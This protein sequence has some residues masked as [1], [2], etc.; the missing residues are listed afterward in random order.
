MLR[1]RCLIQIATDGPT[2]PQG[3]WQYRAIRV[4]AKATEDADAVD[5][6][7]QKWGDAGWQL[8]T[9][10]VTSFK[11]PGAIGVSLYMLHTLYWRKPR[12]DA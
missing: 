1:D 5:R 8:T 4:F 12:Q 7:V 9:A 10:T 6:Q 2:K 11:D 3:E